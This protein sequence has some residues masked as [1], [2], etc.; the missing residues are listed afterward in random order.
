MPVCVAAHPKLETVLLFWAAQL[1]GRPFVGIDPAWSPARIVDL[2]TQQDFRLL[3]SNIEIPPD[4]AIPCKITVIAFESASGHSVEHA[5][6]EDWLDTEVSVELPVQMPNPA[7][8]AVILFTSGTT[9]QPKGVEL[10]HRAV[11]Q[12]ALGVCQY[13]DWRP[14]DVFLSIGNYAT[15]SGVRNSLVATA[16]VGCKLLIP[17]SV[18]RSSILDALTI[19]S[20]YRA[21]IMGV[22]PAFI[23]RLAALA[24]RLEVEM[25]SSLRF[26]VSSG[27]DL[28]PDSANLVEHRLGVPVYNFYGLTETTG[29]CIFM[30]LGT[31]RENGNS[32]GL[33]VDAIAQIVTE[34]DRVIAGSEPGE[35]RIYSGNLLSNYLDEPGN[36]QTLMHDGWLYSGDIGRWSGDGLIELRGRKRDMIKVSSGELIYLSEVEQFLLRHTDNSELAIA[37]FTDAY[38][39]DRMAC[40]IATPAQRSADAQLLRFNDLLRTSLGSNHQLSCVIYVNTFPRGANEKVQKNELVRRHSQQLTG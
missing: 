33:P 11:W 13:F 30:P 3:F 19:M 15:V 8:A 5:R 18:G 39:D 24:P 4:C 34:D 10:A 28:Q 32:I 27:A 21:T 2:M 14:D 22:V 20:K 16:T 9:G 26:F 6:F 1:I 40:F 31:R 35:L 38:G 29:A 25:F 12:S 37:R 36:S 23:S 7:S 17:D